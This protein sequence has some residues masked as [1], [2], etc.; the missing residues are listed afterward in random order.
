MTDKVPGDE[1]A[2]HHVQSNYPRHPF[3]AARASLSG[4]RLI[5]VLIWP[6]VAAL[7]LAPP[8]G[9]QWEGDT[10][11]PEIR[12]RAATFD[13]LIHA[14]G[15]AAPTA[16]TAP[17]VDLYLVQ[18]RGPIR[19]A[20][21]D[22]VAAAGAELFD[23]IPDYAFVARM[24]TQ[25]AEKVTTL[26]Y[27]RW[28][29]AYQ[30]AYRLHP[31]LARPERWPATETIDVRVAALPGSADAARSQVQAAGG[32]VL[33][34]DES[35]LGATLRV[36]ATPGALRE[37]AQS[38]T[39][40]WIEP[41]PRRRLFNDV[42]R[43]PNIMDVQRV[44]DVGLFGAGQIVA[45]AD[46]G[47]DVGRMDDLSADF[48]GRVIATHLLGDDKDAWNDPLGHGTHVAG[49]IAG[50][51]VLSGS[52]PATHAYDGSLAG[53][54]PEASLVVQ[55]FDVDPQTGE[56][57]GL[58][59]NLNALF[60][61]AYDDG[62]RVHSN[63]WGSDDLDPENPFGGYAVDAREVDEFV[64]SH[65]DMT[66][67]FA[68]GNSGTDSLPESDALPGDG[69]IDPDS[70]SPPGTAKNTITVGASESLRP[71]GSGGLSDV[72]WLLVSVLGGFLK[73]PPENVFLHDPISL[74]LVSDNPQGMAAFSSRGPTDDGRIKP[75]LVAPGT[76]ILS[77]RSHD[78]D[79]DPLLASWG[80]YGANPD[81][82][83]NGGTSMATPLAAGSAVLARQWYAEQGTAAPSAALIKATLLNGAEDLAP[84]Q[85]GTGATQEMSAR[86]N[87]VEGWGRV[88][89]GRSLLAAVARRT[90]FDDHATGLQTEDRI[91]YASGAFP[92]YV[93][94]SASLL[95]ITLAWTDYPAS[96]AA[97]QQLVNDLDL[98]VLGP[99]GQLWHGN[100]VA[101][102]RVN[103][104]ETVI[105]R[106]PPR[107][108]Y[109]IL[110]VAHNVPQGPQ[111]YALAVGGPISTRPGSVVYVPL[112]GK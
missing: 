77:A 68:A 85:Y 112:I 41:A 111:P 54:A 74:D 14:P 48:H 1:N 10:A 38:P 11:P 15:G 17:P 50:S 29:G 39:V 93:V 18:F 73:D 23:Y 51:G 80:P 66:I 47:L 86:P 91:I 63:S 105:V 99:G 55:A 9:A 4:R 65:P 46:T 31:S 81:Y 58:P 67:L 27:V 20:W 2:R 89:L 57:A 88:N 32:S 92:L 104:V 100:G 34:A 28:V 84:G 16:A 44:W 96:P 12:L 87:N 64:W 59:D 69:I 43:Q 70:I 42:A 6:L 75:D 36:L 98:T 3:P 13:P 102:D 25:Q 61:Q 30:P 7:L 78:P 26:P 82:V 60:Q 79:F 53:V 72:P 35:M 107:G 62:A 103:N 83:F 49:S 108:A 21:K 24:T 37:L 40:T 76:N 101:E 106:Q 56:I 109:R 8:A 33:S 45:L 110:V 90:W 95:E 19:T 22:G 52:Q 5:A 71:A 97:A 94:S